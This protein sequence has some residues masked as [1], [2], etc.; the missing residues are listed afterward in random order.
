M[1]WIRRAFILMLLLLSSAAY[2][3]EPFVFQGLDLLDSSLDRLEQ[4][5]T[6]Q[7]KNIENLNLQLNNFQMLNLNMTGYISTLKSQLEEYRT[8]QEA[9]SKSL[10]DAV[11]SSRK[12]EI[13]CKALKITL[14]IT[15]PVAVIAGGIITYNLM[16]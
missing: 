1:R 3:Q 11:K 6:E 4:N 2:S 16:R 5:E 13:Q 9:T 8:L 10:E 15:I 7:Q 12:Y 14:C